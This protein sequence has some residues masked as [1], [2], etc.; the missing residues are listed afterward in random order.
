MVL[1]AVLVLAGLWLSRRFRRWINI[2]L[3]VGL[4][5]V[6]VVLVA[7]LA[8]QGTAI[9]RTDDAVAGSLTTADLVAQARAAA[10]DAQSQEALTL[11]NRGNGTAN[12]AKWADASAIVDGALGEACARGSDAC[13]LRDTWAEYVT[14]HQHIRELDDGGDWDSAVA[15]SLGHA[16]GSS[17]VS[18]DDLTVTTKPF[19]ELAGTSQD[20]VRTSSAAVTAALDD[21]TNGLSLM[22]A[23][24]FIAGIFVILLAV[25]GFGQRLR[26]YR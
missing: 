1:V 3:G 4:V 18:G 22:R 25:V 23:L 15:L 11:I 16:Y 24:V 14:G 17:T 12:E 7:G 20:V 9:N 21:A 5:A 2:P 26:E 13:G 6:V 8:T 19:T 10:F